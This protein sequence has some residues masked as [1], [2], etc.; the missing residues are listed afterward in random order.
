MEDEG[1]GVTP[2]DLQMPPEEP[3][4]YVFDAPVPLVEEVKAAFPDCPK[5]VFPGQFFQQRLPLFKNVRHAGTGN[6]GGGKLGMETETGDYRHRGP[7][8]VRRDRRRG[9]HFDV[10]WYVKNRRN[11]SFGLG[12]GARPGGGIQGK[13]FM[14]LKLFPVPGTGRAGDPSLPPLLRRPG[15]ILEEIEGMAVG[16]G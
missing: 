8:A 10:R 13:P 12:S 3:F 16:V 7:I 1:E 14:V 5:A 2:G 9:G 4:L 15:E 6:K 11:V